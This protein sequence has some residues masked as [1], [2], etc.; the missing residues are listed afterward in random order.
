MCYV[1]SMST[2]WPRIAM[3]AGSGIAQAIPREH[4]RS[5]VPMTTIAGLPAL[6]VAGHRAEFAIVQLD[7]GWHSPTTVVDILI[8]MGR[9]HLY[10]GRPTEDVVAVVRWLAN[11]GCTHLILTNAAGGLHP[12]LRVGD[13]LC[14]SDLWNTTGRFVTLPTPKPTPKP[15]P[16][17]RQAVLDPEWRHATVTQCMQMGIALHQGTYVSV[18]GPSYETRAEIRMYRRMGADVIG[19]STALEAATAASMGMKVLSLSLVTNVL[20]DTTQRHLHHDEVLAAGSAGA[21]TMWQAVNA[22]VRAVIA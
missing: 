6:H 14:S 20:S 4:I 7:A 1:A 10:E 9:T 15:T 21:Q 18:L 5:I 11:Q 16:N 22:A 19:M 12:R 17:T 13:L 8:A 3:I 2:A